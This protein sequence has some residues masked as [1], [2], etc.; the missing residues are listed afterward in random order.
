MLGTNSHYRNANWVHRQWRTYVRYSPNEWNIRRKNEIIF[1][2]KVNKMLENRAQ[3]NESARMHTNCFQNIYSII[4]FIFY[5]TS[6]IR[7]TPKSNT[8]VLCWCDCWLRLRLK[9]T[10][11]HLAKCSDNF[12]KYTS[13]VHMYAD[14]DNRPNT[15]KHSNPFQCKTTNFV[16]IP[17]LL[18][19]LRMHAVCAGAALTRSFVLH[20]HIHFDVLSKL[21]ATAT[22]IHTQRTLMQRRNV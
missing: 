8:H 7:S 19:I 2:A 17:F 3:T 13:N 16:R 6:N 14:T 15:A 9:S 12:M 5:K 10:T 4:H 1:N 11:V 18:F 22:H 20:I 21:Q